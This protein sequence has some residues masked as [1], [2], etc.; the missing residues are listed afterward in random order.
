MT[1]PVTTMQGVPVQPDTINNARFQALT[2]RKREPEVVRP[3]AG[4]GGFDVLPIRKSDI[5]S[6]IR[7]RFSGQLVVTVPSGTAA[8]T[9]A[10]PYNLIKNVKLQANGQ[11]NLIDAS[12]AALKAREFMTNPDMTDR[13]VVRTVG[14]ATVN[15]GTLSKATENWGV[16]SNSTVTAGTYP[17]EID[18]LLP[19]AEDDKD[20]T[21]VIFCQTS[22]M[23]INAQVQWANAADVF[24]LTGGAT[25][26]LTGNVVME[27]EKFS[28]PVVGGQMVLPDMSLFHSLV[29][30]QITSISAGKNEPR[31]IGQGAGKQLLRLYYRVLNGA[32]P[33]PLPVTAANYGL[34]QW[35]YGTNENPESYQDGL[36]LRLQNELD[37]GQDIG[38]VWGYLCHDFAS[39]NGFRDSVDMGQTSELRLGVT[40]QNIALTSPVL[41]Y[42]QETVFA[43]GN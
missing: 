38:A 10:W 41:E 37:Y 9:A 4:I 26:V 8:T 29:Q 19:V 11:S 27:V 21:G 36:S 30:T 16:G 5:M 25:A 3:F 34:Q 20:L 12:G 23:D 2:R 17:V 1:A 13:G 18:W 7:I 33:A 31:L 6:R 28:I 42:V 24:T 39:A 35:I 40:L 14:G 22:S 43:A 32:V 15:Q